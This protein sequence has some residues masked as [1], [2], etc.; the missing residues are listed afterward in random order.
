VGTLYVV[1][2]PIGNLEDM[3]FR[4]VRTLR[5]VSL[6]AAEDTRT[7]HILLNH[8][9]IHTPVTS[10]F[11]HSRLTKLDVILGALA[12][13][14]VALI[15]E[16]GMPGLS[17]PG[18]E[19]VRA[20]L[21]AGHPVVPVPGP[22]AAIT[23]LVVSGLPTDRFLFLGFLPR[24]RPERR[25]LLSSVAAEPGTL[26]A[27][28]APHRLCRTLA[29]MADVLGDRPIAVAEELTK[30]FEAVW[31]GSVTGAITHFQAELPRGEFTLA[32]GGAPRETRE[33]PWPA[34]RLGAALSSLL[35]EGVSQATAVRA[36]SRL[37]GRPRRE[38]YRLALGAASEDGE[39][40][41]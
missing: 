35:G 29:D 4:A 33:E 15:S 18:Y 25:R 20:A 40:E 36:L 9:D 5:E 37:T 32:V 34:E 28:E 41:P 19:L 38:I 39:E 7:A 31:R 27:Y 30:R 11:E 17:D 1:G 2:T 14:D 6:I 21:E 26:V 24:R 13:G 23:A 16:A 22:V 3:T 8:F 10:Y 12:H